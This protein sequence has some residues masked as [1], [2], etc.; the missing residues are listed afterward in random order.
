MA[1]YRT[2]IWDWNGTLADDAYASLLVVNDIL[3][4]RD[5]PPIT[6]EQLLPGRSAPG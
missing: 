1:H 6:M 5:M 4:K 3:A 2:V